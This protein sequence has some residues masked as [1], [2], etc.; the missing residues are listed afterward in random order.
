[1]ETITLN[2]L[3][4]HKPFD[5]QPLTL[6]KTPLFNLQ[7]Y[8]TYSEG[9]KWSGAVSTGWG[10]NNT[11]AYFLQ[12]RS[13]SACG[14]TVINY[15]KR[16]TISS[17][18][19]SFPPNVLEGIQTIGSDTDGPPTDQSQAG[20]ALACTSSVA[21]EPAATTSTSSATG[22]S[23]LQPTSTVFASSGTS[24]NPSSHSSSSITLSSGALAGI[25]VTSIVIF[26][27]ISSSAIFLFRH[28]R[29]HRTNPVA[30]L[31]SWSSRSKAMERLDSTA[32]L[33]G[34]VVCKE[35]EGDKRQPTE[36]GATERVEL[37]V[38]ARRSIY[39]M[40]AS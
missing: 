11:D 8:A 35:L 1:V 37:P 30:S 15:S 19:G 14:G 2:L 26:A 4:I 29:K 22:T 36:L 9:N 32:E 34:T 7:P 28:I 13:T 18:T 17:M 24:P 38:N 21:A 23:T 20:A 31:K 16:F 40:P 25:V 3:V 33:A 39:E 12:M 10:G 5:Q 27:A 6:E